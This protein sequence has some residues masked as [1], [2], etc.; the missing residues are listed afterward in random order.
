MDLS[1]V[2]DF[3]TYLAFS[4]HRRGHGIHSPFVFRLVSDVF[5]NKIDPDIVCTIEKTRMS[6]LADAR[7]I[8]VTDLGAGSGIMKTKLRKVSDIAR[9]SSVPKK[10]GIFLANMARAFGKSGILEF[11]TS[12]GI[13]TMYMAVSCPEAEIITMEGCPETSEIA[14]ENFRKSGL[15]NIT[16]LTGSF[17]ELLP[18]LRRK[19]V[20]PGLVFIDGNH[21]GEPVLKYFNEVAEMSGPESVVI[22]DDIHS[23]RSMSDAWNDIK[24]HEKVTSSVDV[25]R[26]GM[27]FFRKGMARYDYTVRY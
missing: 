9:Y 3:L 4:K 10:Y 12:L 7:S 15:D 23:S 25:F 21:R 18:E 5:R 24:R 20:S 13:S 8:N 6:L 2:P 22:L 19:A 26:M 14:K 11:G 27:V 1:S 17:D 16:T